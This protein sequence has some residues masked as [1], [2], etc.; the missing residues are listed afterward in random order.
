MKLIKALGAATAFCRQPFYR[1][2]PCGE[3]VACHRPTRRVQFVCRPNMPEPQDESTMPRPAT[4]N[5]FPLLGLFACRAARHMGYTDEEARLLGY[6]TA[7]LYAIC[8]AKAAA[9][10]EKAQKNH[11]S[12]LPENVPA[13][14]TDTIQFGGQE[15]LVVHG[16]G[17]RLKQA[18]VGHEL[19]EPDAYDTE[20]KR[21]FPEGWHDRLGRAFDAY[22]ASYDPDELN[23]ANH[24]FD[25]YKPWR[26]ENKVGFNRVDLDRLLDWLEKHRHHTG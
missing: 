4:L 24:L 23:R 8:K 20:V 5:R 2:H 6:S 7:L 22:L 3:N 18:L 1:S 13:A 26:D 16:N 21:K 15:F 25:L 10:K 11:P 9:R 19:H 17:K 14:K 12:P